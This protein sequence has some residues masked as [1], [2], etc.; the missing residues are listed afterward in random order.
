[1]SN[2]N[3]HPSTPILSSDDHYSESNEQVMKCPEC[4]ETNGLHLD[5]VEVENASG[6]RLKTEA[7]GEDASAHLDIHLENS[8]THR[9]RR[10]AFSLLGWCELC[11]NEF[12]LTFKHHKGQTIFS[13]TVIETTGK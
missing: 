4:G 10:H 13:K 12:S 3:Q 11:G 6:Q 2:T 9:G 7:K 5:G 8:T 1:M